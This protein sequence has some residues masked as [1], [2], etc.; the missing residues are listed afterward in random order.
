MAIRDSFRGL[1][2]RGYIEYSALREVL[3]T[4]VAFRPLARDRKLNPYRSYQDLREKDPIHRTRLFNGWVLSRYAD[5][6]SVLRDPRFSADRTKSNFGGEMKALEERSPYARA[7]SQMMLF[8]DP[9][10][11]TRLRGLVSKA[12]T[13]KSVGA[14]EP[15]IREIVNELLDEAAAKGG[16]LDI[17]KDLAYPLPVIV[18]AEMVGVPPEDR[19]RFKAWS[20]AVGEGLEPMLTQEQLQ[21]A[22]AAV[23]ALKDYFAGIIAE[24]RREPRED[25][26]SA[27][28]QAEEE[29]DRLSEEELYTTLILLL[30]AG[31][32]TTTNLIG[33]GTLA[34]LRHPGQ[35]E[36]LR[37]Q[38]EIV[39]SAVEELL[40]YDSPVQST[41]R[42]ATEDLDL[43]GVRV[44]K[45]E[46]VVTL[47]G[48]ANRDPEQFPDPNRLDLA[49]K[50][51]RH[52]SFGMGN[53][54]C[55][56]APLARLEGRIA[57]SALAERYSELRLDGIALWRGQV[58]LR[59]LSSLPVAATPA[60]G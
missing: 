46:F 52:L 8:R 40:R 35:Y 54:F 33:N 26:V 19:V 34:L 22:D 31:N 1:L 2:E 17:I 48:A 27:L 56:G 59:G 21:R 16:R 36:L 14:L 4:G 10:D 38:P 23:L 5:C 3:E 45:G 44:R 25:L 11:H 58:I 60:S 37:N 43:N 57:F 42:V 9:P 29:G 53:H 12:F 7:T 55:M 39:E 28:V 20:D 15:R 32:E 6:A 18:I 50:D 47:I 24:R 49:R 13:P 51:N 41:G 30:V